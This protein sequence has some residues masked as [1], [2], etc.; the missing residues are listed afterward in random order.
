MYKVSEVAEMLSIEKVKIFEAMIVHAET[1]TPYTVKERHLSYISDDGVRV[2]EQLIFGTFQEEVEEVTSEIDYVMEEDQLDQF[3]KRNEDKKSELQNDIIE[4]KR[5]INL[6]DKELR[7][8]GGAI[9]NYQSIVGDDIK[10]LQ[11]LEEKLDLLRHQ[12]SD[13]KKSSFFDRLRK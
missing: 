2:L 12:V 11:E 8:Q 9:L 1:L 13:E 5:V 10:W 3:I 4:L 6:L 7:K